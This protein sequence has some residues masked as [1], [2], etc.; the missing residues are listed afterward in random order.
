MNLQK[1][2]EGVK[3]ITANS[4]EVQEGYVFVAIKGTSKDGHDFVQEALQRGAKW[5]FVER[6]LGL[7]SN[8]IIKVENTRKVLGELSDLFYGQPSKKLKVIGITGTNGKSTST[9]LIEHILNAGGI[10]T[11][12]IGT[13]YYRLGNKVYLE[14]GRTTPDP[15][16][17]HKT[18]SEMLL[19]GAKAVS[20]EVSSHALDQYRVWGTTFEIVGFTNLSQDHLDYHGT[21]EEYFRAKL[22][23]FTEYPYRYAIVNAD[24]PYGQRILKEGKGPFITYG[25][26][27]DLRI[28]DF[29]TGL[30]GSRLVVEWEGRRYEFYSNLVGN[31][32]AYNLS[33]GILVGFL[34]GLSY[35]DIKKGVNNVYVPGRFE[36]YKGKG[37]LVVVD[38][39]HTPD[40]LRNVLLTARAI[41]KGRLMVLFGAGGNRDRS[42]RPLMGKVAEELADKIFL[43]SDNPRYEEPMDI[44]EDILSGIEDRTKVVVEP[45]RRMA[46]ELAIKECRE[47]DV[48]VIAGKGHESYQEIKGVRYPFKDSQVVKEVLNV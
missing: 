48:L 30:D 42:K 40:A 37:F 43:T 1:F 9:H 20:C 12:L 22:R 5:V 11:G 16:L 6:D 34:V 24:D 38:Y 35:E 31:F 4:K 36:T 17:W 10:K 13:L 46:I 45:D 15:V 2:L 32:Q 25:K 26:K 19:D 21:M 44:I 28:V 14:E 23:L 29:Y 39:A 18:L 3:G 47:G 7:E 33:L 27:A 41:A 8:R